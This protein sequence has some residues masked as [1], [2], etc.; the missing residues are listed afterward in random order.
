MLGL[1]LDHGLGTVLVLG[2]DHGL[3]TVVGGS[4]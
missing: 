1:G 3:G 2:L 4:D